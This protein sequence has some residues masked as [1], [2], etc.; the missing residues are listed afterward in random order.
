MVAVLPG[1][2]SNGETGAQRH[3]PEIDAQKPIFFILSFAMKTAWNRENCF[4]ACQPG[5][6]AKNNSP[7]FHKPSISWI[8]LILDSES[9]PKTIR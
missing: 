6:V 9:Q 1:S 8:H 2:K 5:N 3:G 4:R 7:L